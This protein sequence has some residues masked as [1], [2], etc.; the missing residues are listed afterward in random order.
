M[1]I[2]VN[3]IIV[4][5]EKGLFSM[6][7]S[8]IRALVNFK[9]SKNISIVVVVQFFLYHF[10]ISKC[11]ELPG[12]EGKL[13]PPKCVMN[14]VKARLNQGLIKHGKPLDS[15]MLTRQASSARTKTNDDSSSEPS[16]GKEK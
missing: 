14:L 4:I 10:I 5:D 6:I 15:V 16:E 12:W 11:Y 1:N 7:K 13:N 9:I 2:T 8:H 3:P